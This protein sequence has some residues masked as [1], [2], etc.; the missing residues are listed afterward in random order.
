MIA[1]KKDKGTILEVKQSTSK[2]NTL[3]QYTKR[4]LGSGNMRAA[5]A[6][7]DNGKN[8]SNLLLFLI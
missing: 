2:R 6:L 7:P 4:T 8:I 3:S 1:S 5:V